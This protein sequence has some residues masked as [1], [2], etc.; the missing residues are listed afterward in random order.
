M[1]LCEICSLHNQ[2][3]FLE[4]ILSNFQFWYLREA[5]VEKKCKGYLYVECKRHVENYNELTQEEWSELSKAIQFGMK[6][7]TQKFSPKKIYILSIGE[8]VPHLHVHLV[9]RYEEN[10]KGLEHLASVL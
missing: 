10:S 2:E 3:K 1:I 5:P 7:I 6:W 9:P 8:K 4:Q